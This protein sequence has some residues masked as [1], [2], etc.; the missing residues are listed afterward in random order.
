MSNALPDHDTMVSNI[1]SVFDTATDAQITAGIDWYA[2]AY[3]IASA[4]SHT[5]RGLTIAQCA[6]VIA[7]LS[8]LQSWGA[9]VNI[10]GRLI[11]AGG[12]TSGYLSR[13]LAKANAILE[14]DDHQAI[15]DTLRGLKTIA[16]FDGIRT[17]GRT[18][19]VC[20][21]R[22][23]YSIAVGER[24]IDV[25]TITKPRYAAIAAAYADAADSLLG[26]HGFDLSGAQ[27][28]AITWL[29]WRNRYWTEGA[30]DAVNLTD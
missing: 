15:R 23:A 9:N 12:L 4:F 21:D 6:G 14:L 29:T 5:A 22:H 10:A 2:D 20:I 13:G 7:A 16:F 11:E 8:P 27:I 28:Q 18:D 24:V 25:P 3:R 30:F 17:R 19:A 26:M 1:L